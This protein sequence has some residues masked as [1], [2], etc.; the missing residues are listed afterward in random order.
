MEYEADREEGQWHLREKGQLS[1]GTTVTDGWLRDNGFWP[2]SRLNIDAVIQ[3]ET[4][5]Y[6]GTVL[7][8]FS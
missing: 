7:D 2:L 1:R 6:F 3:A 8:R 5:S 4:A